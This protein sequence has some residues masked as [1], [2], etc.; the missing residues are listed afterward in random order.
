M[1]STALDSF[2]RSTT[3]G[4]VRPLLSYERQHLNKYA[5]SCNVAS[6]PLLV[7]SILLLESNTS[8]KYIL[9]SSIMRL[10]LFCPKCI[11]PWLTKMLCHRRTRKSAV[12]F[13]VIVSR[14]KIEDLIG[15][16]RKPTRECWT[17]FKNQLRCLFLAIADLDQIIAS[18]AILDEKEKQRAASTRVVW[19]VMSQSLTKPFVVSLVVSDFV[20]QLAL[21]VAF[22]QLRWR[23]NFKLIRN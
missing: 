23:V 18:L 6:I 8:R 19:F 17:V 20:M 16:Y 9:Q 3:S 4:V 10:V 1:L 13:L 12:D 11:G 7:Q 14:L 5:L 21:M 2:G 15:D 22:R